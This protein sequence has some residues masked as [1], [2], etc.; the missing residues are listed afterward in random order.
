VD[1]FEWFGE[2]LDIVEIPAFEFRVVEIIKVIER[3][4][5]V[6]IVQQPF[7]NVRTD[8]T[9]AAGDQKIHDQTLTMKRRAVESAPVLGRSNAEIELRNLEHLASGFHWSAPSRKFIE[10]NKP[11][12]RML[13][14]VDDYELKLKSFYDEL[15]LSFQK[16][17]GRELGE[18]RSMMQES[19]DLWTKMIDEMT[20]QNK[21]QPKLR[22]LA[23]IICHEYSGQVSD[24]AQRVHIAARRSPASKQMPALATYGSQRAQ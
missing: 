4:D 15:M 6:P 10:A 13:K 20:K 23:L 1:K 11:Q 17:L 2:Q 18:V 3:P 19:N 12:I 5:G 22:I 7:A 14:L 16:H 9:R 24:R 21:T 8:K